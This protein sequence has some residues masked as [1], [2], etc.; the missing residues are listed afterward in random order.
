MPKK[1]IKRK[2]KK[3]KYIKTFARAYSQDDINM[4][5]GFYGQIETSFNEKKAK[6]LFDQSA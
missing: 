6:T 5:Y 3:M 2:E 4:S 1:N